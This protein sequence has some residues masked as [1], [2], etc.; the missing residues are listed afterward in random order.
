MFQNMIIIIYFVLSP[1]KYD[2]NFAIQIPS[3]DLLGRGCRRMFGPVVAFD[4]V[5]GKMP[6]LSEDQLKDTSR[7]QYLAYRLG[8]ALQ[9]GKLPDQVAGATIGPCCHTR[10]PVGSQLVCAA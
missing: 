4:P 3:A 1:T 5:P 2:L 6:T 7:D 9:S 8:H 10:L